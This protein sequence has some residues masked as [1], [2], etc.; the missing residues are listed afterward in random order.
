MAQCDG[1]IVGYRESWRKHEKGPLALLQGLIAML[2]TDVNVYELC[3]MV[4]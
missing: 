3:L 1:S 2:A 4:L